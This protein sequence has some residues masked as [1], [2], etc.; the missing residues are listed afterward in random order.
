MAQ[1]NKTS[2][3]YADH[4]WEVL[5]SEP[6]GELVRYTLQ[7]AGDGRTQILDLDLMGS[8]Q[9]KNIVTLRTAVSLLRNH[10]HLNISTRALVEGIRSVAQS[11]GLRGRW[12]HLC[13][14]P[15]VVCDTGHNAH[16]LAEVVT[17]IRA[18]HY[19]HLFM[20]IGMVDDKDFASV[21]PLMPREAHY[22]FT[23]ASV[24][25]ALP[26]E[27]LADKFRHEGFVGDVVANVHEAYRHAISL[28]SA[29]DMIFIG[30]STFVVADLLA[31]E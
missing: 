11:T 28:A 29:D 21:I 27:E 14:A 2:I 4:T 6:S 20:V 17:Q 15:L 19:E 3:V 24:R 31:A 16:G 1:N 23:Q 10:T 5:E 30:G 25:R 13:H 8:Y 9:R 12:Q 26:A 7:R 18:Q 22:I